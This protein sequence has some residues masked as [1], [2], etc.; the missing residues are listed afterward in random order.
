MVK[1]SPSPLTPLPQ[2]ERGITEKVSKIK[3]LI[4]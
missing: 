4:S 1:L 2:G 3:V